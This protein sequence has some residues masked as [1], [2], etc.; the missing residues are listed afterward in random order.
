MRIGLIACCKE[1]L[2]YATQAQYL[3]QSPMF[4]MSMA[5]IRKRCDEWA[6]LSAKHGLV[7]PDQVLEPYDLALKDLPRLELERWA[8]AVHEQLI[9]RWSE[10]AI[11]MILAGHEYRK[12]VKA[13]PMVEDVIEHWTQMRI[14]SGMRRSRARMGIGLILKA[15]K[16]DRSYY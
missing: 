6:I 1:K 12:A 11:Y 15:L 3:Y 9:D 2:D 7:M 13:M 16:E 4:K 8:D 5:W 10:Q 14:D